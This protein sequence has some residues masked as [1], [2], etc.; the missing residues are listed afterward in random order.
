MPAG[1]KQVGQKHWLA[2]LKNAMSERLRFIWLYVFGLVSKELI[3]SGS[4]ILDLG[5]WILVLENGEDLGFRIVRI[6]CD[7]TT[8][9]KRNLG[10]RRPS[11][12]GHIYIIICSTLGSF[13]RIIIIL[14]NSK[15]E[16]SILVPLLVHE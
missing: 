4:W 2:E 13:L 3:L 10:M 11:G 1:Q 12:H 16:E 7:S 9:P 8:P 5:S 15:Q 14:S 6:R